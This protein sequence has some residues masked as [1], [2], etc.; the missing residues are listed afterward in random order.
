MVDVEYQKRNYIFA[1][2]FLL[3]F[4]RFVWYKFGVTIPNLYIPI[5]IILKEKWM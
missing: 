3:R 2:R 4:I 5:C 1:L